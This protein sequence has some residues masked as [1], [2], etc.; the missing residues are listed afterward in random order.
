MDEPNTSHILY[1]LLTYSEW[2]QDPDR[3]P[4][5]QVQQISSSQGA[6]GLF[7]KSVSLIDEINRVSNWQ[8]S[9]KFAAGELGKVV[10]ILLDTT[11]E[12]RTSRDEYTTVVG[13]ATVAKDPMPQWRRMAWS[14]DSTTLAVSFSNGSIHFY[15]LLGSNL[16]NIPPMINGDDSKSQSLE[17][18]LA[19]MMFIPSRTKTKWSNELLVIN[20]AGNLRSY[21]VSPT[22]SFL[23]NHSFSL[24]KDGISA[25]A[26]HPAHNLLFVA[27]LPDQ[28]LSTSKEK[29][30]LCY[31]V[32]VWRLLSD[33]P[34]YKLTVPTEKELEKAKS[35]LGLWNK[36]SSMRS[37]P[38]MSIVFRM[39]ISL[40]GKYLA[41][42][43]T[44]G[45]VS[46]WSLPGL[47]LS[48]VWKLDEQ[49]NCQD[50]K[51]KDE[52]PNK[53]FDWDKVYPIDISWWPDEKLII[54]RRNGAVSVCELEGLRNILGDRPEALAGATMLST[55]CTEKGFLALE[56]E[57]KIISSKK[58][59]QQSTEQPEELSDKE[60]EE[61][62]EEDDTEE[63]DSL[64]M[65]GSELV[66]STI[67]YVTDSERFRPE[68]KLPK[69]IKRTYRLIALK[70]TTPEELF[71]RK[72]DNEEYV[73]ALALANTYNLDCDRVYQRQW[74]NSAVSVASIHDCLSKISKCSWVLQ[75]CCERVPETLRAAKELL[76][77]GLKM[78]DNQLT[79]I[80]KRYW[81]AN[82]DSTDDSIDN[83]PYEKFN[84]MEFVEKL[85][86]EILTEEEKRNISARLKL[87]KFSDRLHTYQMILKNE[88][89][90]QSTSL[91]SESSKVENNDVID[92]E[93]E[94]F[95]K[96]F[97]DRFRHQSTVVSAMYYAQ[98]GDHSAVKC[99]FTYHGSETL[100]YWLSIL[101]NFPETMLPS[102]YSDLLPE[103]SSDGDVFEW[104]VSKIRDTDWCESEKF[105][106]L[107]IDEEEK[108]EKSP[109]LD[110]HSFLTSDKVSDWYRKR[111]YQIES[112]S[113]LVDPALDLIHLARQRHIKGL[114]DLHHQLFTL[115][116]LVYE[117]EME[118][119]TLE[120]LE[121]MTP[122]E[123]ALLLI[124]DATE[125][126]F[127]G[128]LL[129]R[130]VP[131]VDRHEGLVPNSRK[132]LLSQLF[133][134]L[135]SQSLSLPLKLFQYLKEEPENRVMAT[136][137][138]RISLTLE[139]LYTNATI[140]EID[141][142]FVILSCLPEKSTIK[143]NA[144]LEDLR[145]RLEVVES[146]LNTA[147]ILKRY[148][149]P[150]PLLYIHNHAQ[151]LQVVQNL[152]LRIARTT[153]NK[154]P[155]AS[156]TEWNQLLTD[157]LELQR[158]T[159]SCMSLE[160]CYELYASTVLASGNLKIIRSAM[161]ILCCCAGDAYRKQISFERSVFLV[162][163]AAREYFD[164][165]GS[166]FDPGMQNA[167]ACLKLIIEENPQ[168][169]EE[170][171]LIS[172]LQILN[173]F[174]VTL[175]PMQVR[176]CP[177]RMRLIDNCLQSH[178]TAYR[179]HHKLLVLAD[180]LR[181]C[182]SSS[183]HERK[184]SVLVRVAEAAFSAKDYGYCC[185]IC[186]TLVAEEHSI[187]WEVCQKLGQCS[188]F[189]HI[190]ARQQL[191][192]FAL[193][194]CSPQ[195]LQDLLKTRCDLEIESTQQE[196]SKSLSSMEIYSSLD[197]DDEFVDALTS[198]IT[199]MKEF[200]P[201][202]TSK[203]QSTTNLLT[204]MTKSDF[205]KNSFNLGMS[206]TAS[207]QTLLDNSDL[208]K[209]GFP[210][211]YAPLHPGCHRS[212]LAPSFLE[213][214]DQMIRNSQ[215][216]KQL[217]LVQRL[218]Q[219][220]LLEQETQSTSSQN[221]VNNVLI[222]ASQLIMSEDC[223]LGLGY[224]FSLSNISAAEQ[225]F[226]NLPQTQIS[227]QLA[228]YLYSVDQIIHD[229]QDVFAMLPE[230]VVNAALNHDGDIH[231]LIQK[232]KLKLEN[233]VQ[234][235]KMKELDCGVNLDRFT[236]DTQYKYDSILGLAICQEW[237]KVELALELGA[238]YGVSGLEVA[239]NH[240]IAMLL[241]GDPQL[242]IE[243]ISDNRLTSLLQ[244]DSELVVKRLEESVFQ[245]L[246][247]TNHQLMIAYYTVLQSVAEK[248]QVDGM[249]PKDHIKLL[250]KVKATS[251]A[252][253]Y[254]SLLRSNPLTALR[255][256]LNRDSAANIVKLFKAL[257]THLRGDLTTSQ[258]YTDMMISDFF[259]NCLGYSSENKSVSHFEILKSF[260]TKVSAEDLL[261]FI[262]YCVFS[263]KCAEQIDPDTRK[264]FITDAIAFCKQQQNVETYGTIESTLEKWLE[265]LTET[266]DAV[267]FSSVD[268]SL[269]NILCEL[270]VSCGNRENIPSIMETAVMNKSVPF[271]VLQKKCF[272][273]MVSIPEMITKLLKLIDVMD[274]DSISV[275][276]ERI[277]SCLNED[278]RDAEWSSHVQELA[279][280]SQLPSTLRVLA[281]SL[282]QR[283]GET[284]T[285]DKLLMITIAVLG[286]PVN[287]EEI[288]D[289]NARYNLFIRILKEKNTADELFV[290]QQ[291]LSCWPPFS[292]SISEIHPHLQL[293]EKMIVVECSNVLEYISKVFFENKV[294]ETSVEKVVYRLASFG[295]LSPIIWLC[296]ITE[297]DNLHAT[298]IKLLGE[299]KGDLIPEQIVKRTV[300]LRLTSKLVQSKVYSVW[301]E[302]LL[303][304][305]DGTVA[306]SAIDQLKEAGYLPE[307]GHLWFSV[308]SIPRP[309]RTFSASLI[310]IA[311]RLTRN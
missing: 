76:Q 175:L 238:L 190:N 264:Q 197:Q 134:N 171:D 113:H 70:S 200:L 147:V 210:S 45:S 306:K 148:G 252:I 2:V 58:R 141:K 289:E 299:F 223:Q 139:C 179:Q 267:D 282:L 25:A 247:G 256:A 137:E 269:K 123:K 26:W 202:W 90:A 119:L 214:E 260:W 290:V 127:V 239:L 73:E 22:D 243:H 160:L 208:K 28:A 99:L 62:E 79:E 16:F 233:F 29:N 258:L 130:V 30:G 278:L 209:Q 169:Q 274:F 235:E 172:S 232:Y 268:D 189:S 4:D 50:R 225:C 65:R 84:F 133:S 27:S 265:N 185:S 63:K 310:S 266:W 229:H 277:D 281:A 204:K 100:N 234:T 307:A 117:L 203:L 212:I 240:V 211:F 15:D 275:L 205:W 286:H 287:C 24:S 21:F 151:D 128:N 288:I 66:K 35:S 153:A 219:S 188:E 191:I 53:E 215:K 245:N 213:D 82:N 12:I 52:K 244:E 75:E 112:S 74:R 170:L 101:E 198:P 9:C 13:K 95:D 220:V 250:K 109:T 295:G 23:E 80:F 72:I 88:M 161:K 259:Y 297:S 8:L 11:L 174:S 262:K 186:N 14:P 180:K 142:A 304:L 285:N 309:L 273:D 18:A 102:K 178:P 302:S 43:H 294:D 41:C 3:I 104:N 89:E 106:S 291:L 91:P 81:I 224:L 97:Y 146:E 125:E 103:C 110:C 129:H 145:K 226:S 159:F 19:F 136:L 77:F 44:C 92:S 261:N 37:S 298:A 115:D 71:S 293:I 83:N 31:G 57:F 230:D 207:R 187:G 236:K 86:V 154:V 241:T 68:R 248:T 20:Y 60:E 94:N 17:S 311:Q 156:E 144:E 49:P 305:D 140:D 54:A 227:L 253:D 108:W 221:S 199:P 64:F 217:T 39:Q 257:P 132:S 177:N 118:D 165:A 166:L 194:H 251:S 107:N 255:P 216:M 173:E 67:Y 51:L 143:G 280:N 201:Q 59:H 163:Q 48:G 1:D 292:E 242:A 120:K 184:G 131:Y 135:S 6:F 271:T 5:K 124:K 36:I 164:S 246:N 296:L 69:L 7:R 303:V 111:I 40:Q 193:L 56:S 301:V 218:L 237:E 42:L 152:V 228:L 254:R 105:N 284:G 150:K 149:Q 138:D 206:E 270:D 121:K 283:V 96:E 10:A 98:K 231:N 61:N 122:L 87:L 78:T 114:D 155:P 249:L 126:S 46:V 176:L 276:L 272:K 192:A 93:L 34:H 116:M 195:H 300:A 47:R 196:I 168:I 263:R 182:S 222:Q 38:Q 167:K 181:I 162:L 157:I 32:T 33:Y 85:D 158:N 55:T 308:E 183:E 279:A